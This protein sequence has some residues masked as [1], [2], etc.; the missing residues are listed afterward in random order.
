MK[1]NSPAGI[2]ESIDQNKL[3]LSPNPATNQLTIHTSSFHANEA[4]MVSVMNVMGQEAL[5]YS[6]SGVYPDN[7]GR[8]GR[9][10]AIDVSKLSAGIYFLQLK[11]E[12]GRVVKKFVKE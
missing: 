1:Y 11:S 12:S 6:L 7:F 5:S 8:E 2:W 3:I 4:V 9:G 10:E